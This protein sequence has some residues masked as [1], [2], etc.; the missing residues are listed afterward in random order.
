MSGSCIIGFGLALGHASGPIVPGS[1]LI[2]FVAVPEPFMKPDF[3][4]PVAA[5]CVSSLVFAH[6]SHFASWAAMVAWTRDAMSGGSLEAISVVTAY[7]IPG[8]R[9]SFWSIFASRSMI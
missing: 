3:L 9:Y 1:A 5:S 8:I 4:L 2:M 7:F 6:I